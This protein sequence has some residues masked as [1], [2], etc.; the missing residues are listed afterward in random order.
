MPETIP[1]HVHD[2]FLYIMVKM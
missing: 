1:F 2:E